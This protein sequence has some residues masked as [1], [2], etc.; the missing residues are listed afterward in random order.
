VFA[1]GVPDPCVK[2]ATGVVYTG[3]NLPPVVTDTGGNLPP[4]PLTLWQI[5]RQYLRYRRQICHQC[6]R[7]RPPVSTPPPEL[8]AK[9][10]AGVVDTGDKFA[11][12]VIDTGSNFAADVV[13]YRW[14]TLTCEY[15]RKFLKKFKMTLALFSGAWGKIIHEKNLKQKIL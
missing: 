10:A 12:S 9:F 6:R 5:C 14:C 15:F 4:V 1:T 3:G 13:L 7:H 11:T 2:F 8:V